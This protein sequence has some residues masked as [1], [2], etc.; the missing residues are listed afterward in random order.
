M[1]VKLSVD[2]IHLLVG[3]V[4]VLYGTIQVILN[5]IFGIVSK[6]SS[7]AIAAVIF[8]FGATISGF[9]KDDNWFCW[10]AIGAITSIAL[11]GIFGVIESMIDRMTRKAK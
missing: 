1:M 2:L 10:S 6:S 4:L 7:A 9:L 3:I 5:V 11:Y 8:L